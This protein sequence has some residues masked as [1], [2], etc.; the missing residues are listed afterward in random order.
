MHT[1]AAKKRSVDRVKRLIGQLQGIE[2][3]I[4]QDKPCGELLHAIAGCRGA[5]H[6]LFADVLEHQLH[7]HLLP[8]RGASRSKA[9]NDLTDVI[10][11]Y[12]P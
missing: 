11:S 12:L 5:L 9:V 8:A 3:A 7:E 4:E 2:R 6:G 10:H 1:S